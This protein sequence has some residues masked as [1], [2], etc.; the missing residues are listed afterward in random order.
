MVKFR[1]RSNKYSIYNLE[2]NKFFKWVQCEF[3][4]REKIERY[5]F[6][7]LKTRNNKRTIKYV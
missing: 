6:K 2:T 3:F 5:N 1:I 7:I 4:K